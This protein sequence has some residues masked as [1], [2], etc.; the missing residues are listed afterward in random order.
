MKLFVAI[1]LLTITCVGTLPAQVIQYEIDSSFNTG[2]F[3]SRGSINELV[4]LSNNGGYLVSGFFNHGATIANG[5][6]MVGP[7]GEILSNDWSQSMGPSKITPYKNKFLGYGVE[8]IQWFEL[9][10]TDYSFRFEFQKPAYSGPLSN[11]ALDAMVLSD[12]HIF[13]AGRFFTDSTLMGTPIASQGLRQLCMIDSTGAP[14]PGFPMLRCEWPTDAEINSI[15]QLSTGE[16]IISGSFNEVDGYPYAKVAKLNADFSVNTDFQPVFEP[17][18]SA[19]GASLSIVDSQDR[20]WVGRSTDELVLVDAPGYNSNLIRLLPNGAIDP[21]YAAPQF[22]GYFSGTYENPGNWSE[23]SSKVVEDEDGTFILYGG[24][25]EVNGVP[26]RRLVKINDAGEVITGAFSSLSAD[27]ATWG[28]WQGIYGPVMSAEIK[29]IEKLPD[30]K[31]LIGGQFS[32]FGGEPYSCLVRLQP[33]GFVGV[34]EKEGKG[35]LKIW[36]NP[37][38]NSIHIELT[39]H[40]LTNATLY[41]MQGREVLS[42]PLS[43]GEQKVD[44]RHLPKGMYLLRATEHGGEIY[45][46]KLIVQ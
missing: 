26:M 43:T 25:I 37:A 20:I 7:S 40:T 31:L 17:N 34:N 3:Y 2:E 8:N 11:K 32:S 18:V 35:R 38:I 39:G 44:V 4:V 9:G 16:Y 1:T 10:A 23:V 5:V 19:L 24:F 42:V 46:T 15:R 29:K 21:D 28:S 33:S 36:P 12:D 30:G 45:T 27:S 41:D 6:S 13:V 22:G 14:V